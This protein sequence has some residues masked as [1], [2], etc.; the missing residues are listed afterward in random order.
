MQMQTR[1]TC[2]LLC[3]GDG[4]DSTGHCT[5]GSPLPV[6]CRCGGYGTIS[7]DGVNNPPYLYE[8]DR[9]YFIAHGGTAEEFDQAKKGEG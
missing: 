9:R 6:C 4:N 2:C 7:G 3:G 5:N 8:G 1:E